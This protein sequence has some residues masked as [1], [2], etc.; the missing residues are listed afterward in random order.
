[1]INPRPELAGLI[2]DNY[3]VAYNQLPDVK[4]KERERM[5]L[6]RLLPEVKAQIREYS[7]RPEVRLKALANSRKPSYITVRRRYQALPEIKIRRREYAREYS[8]RPYHQAKLRKYWQTPRYKELTRGYRQKPEFKSQQRQRSKHLYA[9]DSQFFLGL[10]LRT[11]LGHALRR[12][13]DG[14]KMSSNKYGI[15]YRA[16]IRHLGPKPNDGRIYEIDHIRPFCSFDLRNP[17]HVR[18]VMRPENHRWLELS[19]HKKKSASERRSK[20]F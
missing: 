3:R 8:H 17:S 4:A 11:L 16:I 15:D 5:R 13:A 9:T 2:G 14:K 10:K 20:F 12:Y 18:E 1:M 7:Q 6:R 19:E